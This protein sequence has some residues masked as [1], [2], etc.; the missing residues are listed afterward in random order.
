[1]SVPSV[2]A[3]SIPQSGD[4]TT[5]THAQVAPKPTQKPT[6]ADNPESGTPAATDQDKAKRSGSNGSEDGK[7]NTAEDVSRA[8][9]GA[10]SGQ[11]EAAAQSESTARA[12]Q[13]RAGG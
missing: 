3:P 8:G 7:S 12:D 1:V 6:P 9:S 10:Q 11:S 5:T 4:A 2:T 13:Q